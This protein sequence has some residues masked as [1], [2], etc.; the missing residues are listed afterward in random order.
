M[1]RV[2]ALVSIELVQ[3]I[4]NVLNTANKDFDQ[5]I[6]LIL[7]RLVDRGSIPC[8]S[9]NFLSRHSLQLGHGTQP[10]DTESFFPGQTKWHES[11]GGHF[12]VPRF[13]MRGA[14]PP[15]PNIYDVFPW[16]K[17]RGIFFHRGFKNDIVFYPSPTGISCQCECF[18]FH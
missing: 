1:P 9:R 4:M 13:I 17:G 6:L 8:V 11:G 7:C 18:L 3:K 2:I 15:L 14:V 5:L 16:R 12:L 10:V